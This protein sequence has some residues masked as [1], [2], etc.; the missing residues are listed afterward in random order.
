MK[1][2]KI[3]SV[4]NSFSDDTMWCL[5]QVARAFGVENIKLGNLYVGGCSIRQHHAHITGDLPVYAYRRNTGG[6]Y[7]V[8]VSGWRISEA[9]ASGDWDVISIQHGTGDGS[10]YTDPVYYE[11]LGALVAEVKRQAGDR[12]KIAFN[13]TWV[14]E[15]D[16]KHHEI[17]AFGGDQMEI[18]RRICALTRELILPMEGI[19]MVSPTGTAIQNA[20]TMVSERLT[21]DG[22]HL[23]KV[24]GRY[25]AALTFFCALTGA[26][27][28]GA[29][30]PDGITPEAWSRA[31]AAAKHAISNPFNVT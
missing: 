16:R 24:F 18:Y 1:E 5:P 21:R 22:Y 10:Y 23:D 12:T 25:V 31:V 20:R 28:D 15:P 9:I 26:S 3:L 7:W 19:D 8:T 11:K 13:M 6:D 30:V 17:E 27:A 4:G 29:R 14:G 2:I